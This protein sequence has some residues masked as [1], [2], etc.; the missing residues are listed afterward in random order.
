[1]ANKRTDQWCTSIRICV[2]NEINEQ[3]EKLQ[4]K[5]RLRGEK[6]GK[7]EAAERYIEMLFRLHNLNLPQ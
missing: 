2:D 5:L 1:M 3:I 6:I 7:P 4:A